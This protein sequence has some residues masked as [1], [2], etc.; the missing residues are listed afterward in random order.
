VNVLLAG[1][2]GQLGQGLAE[3]AAECGV[4]L[5]PLVRPVAGLNGPARLARTLPGIADLAARTVTGD[6]GVRLW[7]LTD[8]TLDRLAPRVD[9]VLNVAAQTNWA[10]PAR[11]L[12]RVN[13]TGALEG[14]RV[15]AA[16]RRRHPRCGAYVYASSVYVA[17]GRTGL[18]PEHPF[19]P[20]D[21]RTEY[22]H[23]KWLAEHRLLHRARRPDEPAVGVA[24]IGGLLGDSVTGRTAKRN[25]LYQ[26]AALLRRGPG[27]VPVA[28][29]GR[30]DMLPRDLAARALL[31][32]TAGVLRLQPDEPQLAHVCAGER[33]PTFLSV[34]HALSDLDP[35]AL[36][37][38]PHRTV[39]V[40]SHLLFRLSTDLP[41]LTPLPPRV[42]N[43]VVGLRYVA[44][45]RVFERHRLARFVDG[46]LPAA[47][48]GLVARLAFGAVR[49]SPDRAE[50]D[51]P[52]ARFR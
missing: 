32:F 24:R 31:A 22:E 33:A 16:L 42:H 34:L 2:T 5:F 49:P 52:L 15:A 29:G 39:P 1:V 41:D 17:G 46:P 45:D 25:S 18:V 50:P 30:V 20:G 36:A 48:P 28:R 47:D 26:L 6:V 3:H 10:A 4:T 43:A 7:G 40:P 23:T 9:V 8:E 38:R 51:R 27:V 21:D 44:L 12:H 35:R 11:D 37:G 14:L 13:V 19:G